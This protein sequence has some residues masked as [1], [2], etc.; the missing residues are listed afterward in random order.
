[1]TQLHFVVED[2]KFTPENFGDV[3]VSGE[4]VV[5]VPLDEVK[6]T[7]ENAGDWALTDV[8]FTFPDAADVKPTVVY[9]TGVDCTGANVGDVKPMRDELLAEDIVVGGR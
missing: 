5:P 8:K 6:L 3:N 4:N 1:V 7:P 2:V 9:L